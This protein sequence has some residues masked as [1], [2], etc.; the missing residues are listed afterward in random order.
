LVAPE[1]RPV[2]AEVRLFP[3]KENSRS[4][5]AGRW[6][7]QASAVPAEGIPGRALR[8]LRLKPTGLAPE[9]SHLVAQDE[10]LEVLRAASGAP[11]GEQPCER[12]NDEE[13]E[14]D[15]RGRVEE[16]LVTRR[17]EVLDPCGPTSSWPWC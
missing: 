10:D 6:S 14:V 13:E 9:H 2:V 17:I 12:P 16:P 3:A 4:R 11:S 1:G 15:H 7:E 8:A 5:G